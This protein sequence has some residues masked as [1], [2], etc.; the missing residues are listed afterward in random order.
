MMAKDIISLYSGGMDSTVALYRYA[1]RVRLA[2][3]FDYGSKHNRIEIDHASRNCRRLGIEHLVIDMDLNRMGFVSDLLTSGGAIPAGRYDDDNMR[4]TV[5]PFRNGIMLSIA[6]GLAESMGCA[7]LMLSNHAG[8]HAIYPDCREEFVRHMGQAIA[9]GTYNH[10]ELFAPFT[11]LSK[12]E[13]ALIGREL[14]VPFEDTYSC[15]EGQEVHCGVC[16]T[17]TERKEALAGFDPTVYRI[18]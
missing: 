6:A 12:R 11:L 15:Y 3:S 18:K 4:S 16:G 2:L 14:G 7:H 10:V 1:D 9:S 5:V 8:D 13:I 17:C